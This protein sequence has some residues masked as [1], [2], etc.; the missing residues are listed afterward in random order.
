M[1][2]FSSSAAEFVPGRPNAAA[3][4]TYKEWVPGQG[5]QNSQP[6]LQN[7]GQQGS[8]TGEV[9]GYETHTVMNMV[10]MREFLRLQILV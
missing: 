1:A 8:M 4:P 2:E 9:V 10:Q 7:S 3:K 5:I 6:A